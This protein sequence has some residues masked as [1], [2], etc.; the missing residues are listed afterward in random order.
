MFFTAS[1]MDFI[2]IFLNYSCEER[3]SLIIVINPLNSIVVYP[4][5]K[6]VLKIRDF[7]VDC[8]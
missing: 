8:F 7:F 4:H 6:Q 1:Y 2:L 5:L 3:N